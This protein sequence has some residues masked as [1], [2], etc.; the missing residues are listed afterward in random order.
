MILERSE[1]ASESLLGDLRN[2]RTNRNARR[3]MQWVHESKMW[4]TYLRIDEVARDLTY[5]LSTVLQARSAEQSSA[6]EA[7][8]PSSFLW[9][10][11]APY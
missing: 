8:L 3:S 10:W 2:D 9:S 11:A 6:R 7:R 1:Q 5:D 4:F